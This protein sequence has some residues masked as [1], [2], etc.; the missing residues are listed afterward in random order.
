VDIITNAEHFIYIEAGAFTHSQT[1]ALEPS[2]SANGIARAL[3]DRIARAMLQSTKDPQSTLRVAVVC[4]MF[5]PSAGELYRTD[6]GPLPAPS[7]RFRAQVVEQLW[8]IRW[9]LTELDKLREGRPLDEYITFSMLHGASRG[10]HAQV[11]VNSCVLVVDE[12]EVLIGCG[13]LSDRCLRGTDSCVALRLKD[14]QTVPGI[15][16]S[17]V[18]TVSVP[19]IL[20]QSTN[21]L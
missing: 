15:L 5:P 20:E 7:V 13:D 16:S 2:P 18:Q 8:C 10:L 12:R 6:D 9:M 21:R 19:S 4:S 17:R 14:A 3:V 1:R 11:F